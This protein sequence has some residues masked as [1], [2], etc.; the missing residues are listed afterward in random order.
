MCI[1]KYRNIWISLFV[2]SAVLCSGACGKQNPG[3]ASNISTEQNFNTETKT[4][5]SETTE[6]TETEEQDS[7]DGY[8]LA[9]DTTIE[10]TVLFDDGSVSVK[11][12]GLSFSYNSPELNIEI[13]NQSDQN[14]Q[15][16][17]GTLGYSCNSVNGFMVHSGYLNADVGPG[18]TAIETVRFDADELK[19]YGIKEV[20]EIKMAVL[21]DDE[22]N[23]EYAVTEPVSIHTSAY[24]KWD[25]TKNDYWSALHSKAAKTAYGFDVI[26]DNR[27]ALYDAESVK[28]SSASLVKNKNDETSLLLEIEN[29]SD[30]IVNVIFSDIAV[31]GL[32]LSSGNWTGDTL[33]RNSRCIEVLNINDIAEHGAGSLEISGIS[34]IANVGF[35]MEIEDTNNNTLKTDDI[36]VSITEEEPINSSGEEVYNNNGIT[37]LS[38]GVFDIDSFYY[39]AVF[40]VKND[41]ES[42]INTD[43]EYGTLSLND[44]MTDSISYSLTLKPGKAGVINV[45][46]SK[47]DAAAAGITS[48]SDITNMELVFDI[49]DYQTY[50]DIDTP[51]VKIAL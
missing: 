3:E 1:M 15:F 11:A 35:C 17:A 51:D 38:K 6:I 4:A 45:E 7:G 42:V 43:V 27:E 10:E 2:I 44:V 48:V 41:T 46:I 33:D 18:K 24:D 16:L 29:T 37:I 22:N 23:Q 25:Q 12:T 21:I 47:D 40:V 5:Y 32:V 20:A 26:W 13:S 14:L 34:Q 31:N 36:N 49:K 28:I 50:D 39:N 30:K 9:L 19:L 8:E